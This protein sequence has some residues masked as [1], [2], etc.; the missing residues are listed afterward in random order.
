VVYLLLGEESE[1]RFASFFKLPMFRERY[2]GRVVPF[3]NEESMKEYFLSHEE[4]SL[5]EKLVTA[6]VPR[7]VQ[8]LKDIQQEK[9]AE[10]NRDGRKNILLMKGRSRYGAL[11]R[12]I[13]E[14]AAA[15]RRNGYNMSVYNAG[16]L[17]VG[18]EADNLAKAEYEAIIACN[19]MGLE[20]EKMK[21]WGKNFVSSWGIILYGMIFD[22]GRL[23]KTQSYLMGILMTWIISKNIIPMWGGLSVPKAELRY[24]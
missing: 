22:C 10:V 8:V 14:L 24:F 5:P 13:E 1:A 23:I 17:G 9:E 2:M 16:A 11:T 18:G 21:S 12:L 3:R 4:R 19:G 15:F 20:F 7:Y 6:D